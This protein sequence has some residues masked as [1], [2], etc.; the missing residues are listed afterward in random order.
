MGRSPRAVGILRGLAG[1]LAAIPLVAALAAA[2]PTPRGTPPP[3]T[4]ARGAPPSAAPKTAPAGSSA[5]RRPSTASTAASSPAKPSPPRGRTAARPPGPPAAYLQAVRGWHAP[6]T[7]TLSVDSHGRPRLVLVGLNTRERTELT[8]ANEGGTFDAEDL[9]RAA[10]ALRDPG[11]GN[12][13]VVDPHLLD[14]LYRVQ[15]HFEAPEIRFLSAYR[16]P[17]GG[18]SNHGRGRAIDFVVPGTSDEDVAR[19]AREQGFCG[20]GIYPTSGFVHLDVRERSYFW[21]DA[22]GP[23]KRN[24]ERGVLPE[25]AQRSDVAATARGERSVGSF[26]IGGNVE[27]ALRSRGTAAACATEPSPPGQEEDDDMSHDEDGAGVDAPPDAP[28]P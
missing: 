23:G 28:R 6:S 17:H 19:F 22:S 9:D 1:G 13:H 3:V 7:R 11:A 16:T 4:P 21:V 20:V 18:R 25:E 5:P 15:R 24:R 12:E 2:D 8:A 26:A 14:V 27:A 10:H